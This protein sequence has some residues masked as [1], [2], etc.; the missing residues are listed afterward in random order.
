[1]IALDPYS[2]DEDEV[3]VQREFYEKKHLATKL[4]DLNKWPRASPRHLPGAD[5]VVGDLG[6]LRGH[7]HDVNQQVR[8]PSP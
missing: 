5:R 1:M 8:G 3:R 6:P 2:A 4:S 7:L